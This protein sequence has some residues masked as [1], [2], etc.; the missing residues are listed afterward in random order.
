MAKAKQLEKVFCDPIKLDLFTEE[1][2]KYN[3]TLLKKRCE[4]GGEGDVI[5]KGDQSI[6]E[7]LYKKARRTVEVLSEHL[8]LSI[9]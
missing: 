6:L 8:L 9:S 3:A 7:E 1:E 4:R 5:G 2:A